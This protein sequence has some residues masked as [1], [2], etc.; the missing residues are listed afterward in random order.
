MNNVRCI[1]CSLI[2]FA[3]AEACKRCGE[4]L[5]YAEGNDP[6]A[7][8]FPPETY[9]AQTSY[10]TAPE[11]DSYLKQYQTYYGNSQTQPGPGKR[12]GVALTLLALVCLVALVGIPWYLKNRG[13]NE[14]ITLS[15]REFKPD[16][17]SFSI[18]M[19]GEPKQNSM[20]MPTPSG[21]INVT[22]YHHETAG[23]TAFAMGVIE[24]P[25]VAANVPV[26]ALFDKALESLANRSQMGV[27]SRKSVTLDGHPGIEVELKPPASAGRDGDKGMMRL[28]WVSPRIYMIMVGGPDSGEAAATRAKFLDSFKLLGSR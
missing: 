12:K 20:N 3:S 23:K 8:P 21:N 1:K 11:P 25:M 4:P 7:Q 14:L 28:Y 6:Y 10:Q 9:S 2:N 16:D 17:G 18:L 24:Y 5:G 26:D 19:P 27:L 22:M 15:W 13:P